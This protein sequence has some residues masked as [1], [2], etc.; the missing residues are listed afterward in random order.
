MVAPGWVG[1]G[2]PTGHWERVEE[3]T[4]SLYFKQHGGVLG[5]GE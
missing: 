4:R 5:W 1:S 2:H 3:L